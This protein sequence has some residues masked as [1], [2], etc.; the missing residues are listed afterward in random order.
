[1]VGFSLRIFFARQIK[2]RQNWLNSVKQ[3][4]L[5]QLTLGFV[6]A[7]RTEVQSA[8]YSLL[9]FGSGRTSN[10]QH[11]FLT[12]T[13]ANIVQRFRADDFQIPRLTQSPVRQI[14]KKLFFTKK[15]PCRIFACA[16]TS[17][18]NRLVKTQAFWLQKNKLTYFGY[19]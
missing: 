15:R 3:T 5:R 17:S 13:L 4:T 16:H 7:G 8:F 19:K 11:Y 18:F 9:G 10:T 2:R 1:M 6:Q 12:S 14:V